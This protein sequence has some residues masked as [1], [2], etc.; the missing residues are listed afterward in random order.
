MKASKLKDK[1]MHAYSMCTPCF[2]YIKRWVDCLSLEMTNLNSEYMYLSMST[3]Y[4]YLKSEYL[5]LPNEYIYLNSEYLSLP[6]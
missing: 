4:I 2:I 5:S 3:E 1:K 6:K